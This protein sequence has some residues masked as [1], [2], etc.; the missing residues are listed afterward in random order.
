MGNTDL[1]AVEALRALAP[2]IGAGGLS[3]VVIAVFAYMQ[4]ARTGRRGEPEKAGIGIS[5]LVADSISIDRLSEEL[6][7]GADAVEKN[8]AALAA[9]VLGFAEARPHLVKFLH[10]AIEEQGD[11]RKEVV[12][13]L[14][15]IRHT[16]EEQHGPKP[17]R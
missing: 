5:A 9:L 12:E 11:F 6:G 16:L 2:L 14:R 7:R 17:R 10:E 4:A 3:G 15:K 8:A 1:T 13:E